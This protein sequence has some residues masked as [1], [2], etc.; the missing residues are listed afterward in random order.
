[1]TTPPPA[2]S[3]VYGPVSDQDV[4]SLVRLIH[5]AFASTPDV[6]E[7]WI[8]PTGLDN[9]RGV[10]EQARGPL[11]SCLLRINMGQ[12]FGG[13]SVPMLGIAGVAVSPESRGQGTAR[14]MMGESMREAREDGF[15]LSGLYAS[16]QGLYRQV[17]FEQAGHR[18]TT[19]L[20]PHRIDVR[21]RE[22]LVRPLTAYDDHAMAACYGQFAQSFAGMLD[23]CPYIWRRVREF[24]DKKYH[25]FGIEGTGGAIDGYVFL[26]QNRTADGIEIEVSDIAF[27]TA[28]DGRRLLGFLADFS[29]TT[30][31]ITINGAP[32]HPILSL[33]T[34]HHHEIVK[35][36]VWMLRI[37]DLTKA[38]T[39]RGYPRHLAA[40]I[41]LNIHDPIIRE[42]DGSWTL[43]VEHGRAEVKKEAAVRPTITCE[44]GALASLYSGFYT[45]TQGALLGWVEGE[46]NALEAADAIFGGF[47][48]PWMTDF[49]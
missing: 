34:S 30:K 33:M 44:V 39:E 43:H 19:K 2:S 10:R 37:T 6:E 13:R 38:L 3:R 12:F 26:M 46:R 20:L 5:H 11:S 35:S 7:K 41:Q 28:R 32:L 8:R 27:T 47:G 45:A 49:F 36:E 15:A 17:G 22:P 9:F 1:M 21:M 31:E 29:T 16:T 18:C 24:R 48:A 14:W 4:P 40:T 23:R 25:G 42:N